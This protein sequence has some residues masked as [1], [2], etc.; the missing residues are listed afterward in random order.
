LTFFILA[1]NQCTSTD[2]SSRELVFLFDNLRNV[3]FKRS[4]DYYNFLILNTNDR[5]VLVLSKQKDK[6]SLPVGEATKVL[7]EKWV[8]ALPF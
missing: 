2:T 1:R 3:G 5:Y 7:P 4:I 8:K 6:F